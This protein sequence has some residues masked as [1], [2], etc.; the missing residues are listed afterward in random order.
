[1]PNQWQFTGVHGVQVTYEEPSRPSSYPPYRSCHG[2]SAAE[3]DVCMKMHIMLALSHPHESSLTV[4]CD[5]V[6]KHMTLAVC[7]CL[8]HDS[9]IVTVPLQQWGEPH[10]G[11]MG[12]RE[13]VLPVRSS[14]QLHA[15]TCHARSTFF[16]S[17]GLHLSYRLSSD[18]L[19]LKST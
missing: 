5:E 3:R 14:R 4:R 12:I 13:K 7:L 10:E 19:K 15:R 17:R 11:R 2:A 6:A 8:L 9:W 16:F 1:M 18:R